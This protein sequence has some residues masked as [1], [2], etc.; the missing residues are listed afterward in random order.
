MRG[1]GRGRWAG[2]TWVHDQTVTNGATGG[3]S[4][5]G[6]LVVPGKGNEMELISAIVQNLDAVNRFSRI[7]ILTPAGAVM[8]IPNITLQNIPA[9]HQG[10]PVPG[11]EDA[12]PSSDES[13]GPGRRIISGEM[14][15]QMQNLATDASQDARFGIVARVRGRKPTVTAEGNADFTTV[16]NEDLFV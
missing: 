8:D 16:V 4:T 12:L 11:P 13:F 6:I 2:R 7:L 3:A 15:L 9:G 5:I 14:Q 10:F 1:R